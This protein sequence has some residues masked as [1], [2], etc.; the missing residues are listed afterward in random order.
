MAAGVLLL[1]AGLRGVPVDPTRPDR[2][3]IAGAGV[4]VARRRCP[5]GSPRRSRSGSLTLMLTRW[6]VAAVGLAALV[7]LWP[8]LFGGR[9][10]E[11]RQ[12]ASLEAL[13]TWTESLRDTIAAHAS[14]EQAIPASTV[15]APPLIRPAWSGWSGRSGP[16]CR[17][18]RRCWSWRPSWTTRPRTW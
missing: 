1:I 7:V 3:G 18:T 16:G 13:V 9:S 2:A 4:V 12:I 14:L 6:P 5:A 11:Q 15:N 8:Q 10:A 17:W